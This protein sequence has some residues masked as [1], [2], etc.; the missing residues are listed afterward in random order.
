MTNDGNENKEARGSVLSNPRTFESG[1][2]P[3][4]DDTV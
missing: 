2:S 3:A 1:N 4:L